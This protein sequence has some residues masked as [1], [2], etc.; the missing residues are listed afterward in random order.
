MLSSSSTIK[1]RISD[2]T[3]RKSSSSSAKTDNREA[4]TPSST[5]IRSSSESLDYFNY[6]DDFA[7]ALRSK[8]SDIA[9][10]PSD[11]FAAQ[12]PKPTNWS[13]DFAGALRNK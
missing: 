1:S 10:K 11:L 6:A 7:Q 2:D 9:S 13:D 4:H 8:S 3:F 5:K 12:L